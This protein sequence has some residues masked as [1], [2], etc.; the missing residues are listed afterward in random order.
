MATATYIANRKLVHSRY[1]RYRG[2]HYDVTEGFPICKGWDGALPRQD[3]DGLIVWA[4][5]DP[6]TVKVGILKGE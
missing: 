6:T 3:K 2:H 5:L 1:F 4:V